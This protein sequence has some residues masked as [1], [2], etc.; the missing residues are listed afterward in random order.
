M[1]GWRRMLLGL[2]LAGL[3]L[4]G[5]VY[6]VDM[7]RFWQAATKVHLAWLGVVLLLKSLASGIKALRWRIAMHAVLGWSPRHTF[8]ATVIGLLAN[9]IFPARLGE[10]LRAQI[11]QKNNQG[12]SGS[13]ALTS[14]ILTQLFD[15]ML[16]LCCLL[17]GVLGVQRTEMQ[18][19][20]LLAVVGLM[21]AIFVGLV[22]FEVYYDRFAPL[23]GRVGSLLPERIA[24]MLGRILGQV[25][26]GLGLLR[27]PWAVS[28]VFFLTL[29]LWN[30]E[31]LCY[32]LIFQALQLQ[33]SFGMLLLVTGAAN[34]AFLA[35]VTPGA[36]G[37]YQAVCIWVLG[38]AG[39]SREIGLLYSL[40]MQGCDVLM[41]LLLGGTFFVR[42]GLQL[43]NVQHHLQKDLHDGV[44]QAKTK[45]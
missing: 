6:F 5:M 35:P 27:K 44:V 28:Q 32:F 17:F 39:I 14:N 25:R 37:V 18:V 9:L 19:S 10:I 33:V 22:V 42:E 26:Q 38:F 40:L 34:L 36:V 45:V 4:G 8:S 12:V 21:V 11:V 30:V 3:L 29:C 2:L 43:G 16:L 41:I 31:A 20:H 24:Q 7:S 13:L 1:R 23:G 15:V